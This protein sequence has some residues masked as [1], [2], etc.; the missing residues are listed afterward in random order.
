MQVFEVFETSGHFPVVRL[1]GY[2][3]AVSVIAGKVIGQ[4]FVGRETFLEEDLELTMAE[5]ND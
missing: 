5:I 4:E 2:L 1:R 3:V